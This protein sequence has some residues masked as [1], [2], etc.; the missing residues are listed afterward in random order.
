MATNPWAAAARMT[1]HELREVPIFASLADGD[2]RWLA[3]RGTETQ[4]DSGAVLFKEG[5]PADAFHVVLDGELRVTK[6]VEG[7][8]TE[9]DLLP[10]G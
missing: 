7:R 2:L 6:M 3:A 1:P 8:E 9:I 5:D 10:T 4:L